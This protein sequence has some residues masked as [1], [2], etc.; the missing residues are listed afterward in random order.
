MGTGR[1]FTHRFRYEAC[2]CCPSGTRFMSPD[3]PSPRRTRP[4]DTA[5]SH[6]CSSHS[7][8]T[9]DA[10]SEHRPGR[11]TSP[12]PTVRRVRSP[13]ASPVRHGGGHDTRKRRCPGS[14]TT[15]VPRKGP[16]PHD[17]GCIDRQIQYVA[18]P[19]GRVSTAATLLQHPRRAIP[20]LASRRTRPTCR[21]HPVS[22]LHSAA[23]Q[24]G[25][26]SRDRHGPHFPIVTGTPSDNGQTCG[27]D[28]PGRRN[29]RGPRR[30]LGAVRPPLDDRAR[31]ALVPT[32][33]D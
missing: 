2:P 4:A 30:E 9:I 19:P 23:P 1:Q 21:P 20:A 31:T 7:V 3:R 28:P 15:T 29:R 32:S 8:A 17:G 18:N 27:L 6:R 16:R 5:G 13:P 12:R 14:T 10:D 33:G 25:Q 22:L 26:R 11:L 24:R